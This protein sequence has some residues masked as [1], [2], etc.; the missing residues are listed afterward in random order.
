MNSTIEAVVLGLALVGAAG[1]G[2]T[3][4]LSGALSGGVLA[5][6]FA[7]FGGE[8]AVA[9]FAALVILGSASTRIGYERK[10]RLGAAED[11]A[12][13]RGAASAWANAGAAAA[14]LII[15]PAPA[16]LVAGLSALGASLSDTVAGEIGLLSQRP[17]RR[18]LF[19][20]PVPPGV[21]GGMSWLGTGASLIAAAV[22]GAIA[23]FGGSDAGLGIAVAVGAVG[24]NLGDSLRGATIESRFSRAWGNVITN[25]LASGS[26]GALGLCLHGVGV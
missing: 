10:R 1:A 13:R 9:G 20:P 8:L 24:G 5:A 15:L 12:G 3:V 4:T 25:F 6:L 22:M 21:D 11:H 19:G 23:G 7:K 2:R 16:A 14:F 17:P 26:G 18:L